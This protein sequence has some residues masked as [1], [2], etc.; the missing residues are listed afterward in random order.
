MKWG[1]K[2]KLHRIQIKNFRNFHNLDVLLGGQIVIVGENKIG[3]TNLIHALRL[4]LDP[5][6]P[7]SARQLHITDFWDGLGESLTSEH[8]INVSVDLTNFEDDED[9]LAILAEH[10][11][12]PQPMI[13]RLTYTFRPIGTLEK[14]PHSDSDFEFFVYGGE[15]P[16]NQIGYEVRSRIPLDVLHAL[17]DAERDLATWTNSPLRPLLDGATKDIDRG[18]LNTIANNILSTTNSILDIPKKREEGISR[19][20]IPDGEDQPVT[21]PLRNL[22]NQITARL[23]DMVGIS[24][25]METTLG[26]SPTDPERLLRAIRLFIDGGKRSVSDASLGS[27][28]LLYLTLKSIELDHLAELGNREHTFLAIEEPE[29]HLHPHLQRL[30][31]RD[32]LH[33]RT[34]K[35]IKENEKLI[36]GNHQTIILTTHSPHIVSVSPLRSIV[37]LKYAVDKKSTIGSS[38]AQIE[39]NKEEVEDLERYLDV[40]RGEILF[41]KGVLLVEGPSEEYLVPAFGKLLGYDFDELGITVCSVSGTNFSPY[42][43][44]L[45]EK[46][47]DIPF[48]VLTDFDPQKNGESLGAPRVLKLLKGIMKPEEFDSFETDDKKLEQ[49]SKFGIFLNEFTLE[50]DLF[51]SGCQQILCQTLIELTENQTTKKRAIDW[52]ADPSIMDVNQ[53]LADIKNIGKGKFSQRLCRYLTIDGCPKYI[54]KAIE[55]VATKC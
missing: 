5:S 29:A 16:T 45:G 9:L 35:D 31:Y 53:F 12:Q 40:N 36:T 17:R 42:V 32:F 4:V 38:T 50:V 23:K 43:K 15:N 41:A 18:E 39:L 30:V 49:A 55:Y 33:L 2:M 20:D 37:L 1:R 51:Q 34:H 13:A 21:K 7:D 8:I 52:N 22:D 48:A 11:I 28:N 25:A 10:L 44:L 6:L 24:Q 46:G 27:A 14:A 26:F 47:L 19:S 3:K 54:K